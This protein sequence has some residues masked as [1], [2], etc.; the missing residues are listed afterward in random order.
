[1]ALAYLR[2]GKTVEGRQCLDRAEQWFTNANRQL[3][4]YKNGFPP[5]IHP[6]DWL[7]VQVLRRETETLMADRP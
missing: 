1:L 4:K 6:S 5:A 7:T 3:A 2:Q